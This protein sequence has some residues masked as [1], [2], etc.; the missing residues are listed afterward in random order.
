MRVWR[1]LAIWSSRH[2]TKTDPFLIFIIMCI[3]NPF[4]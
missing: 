1:Y 3:T 2:L 4:I